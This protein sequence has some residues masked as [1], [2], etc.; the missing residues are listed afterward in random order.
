MRGIFPSPSF[1]TL[2][3]SLFSKYS[4]VISS[5]FLF[6]SSLLFFFSLFFSFLFL[7]FLTFLI[8]FFKEKAIPLNQTIK[9]YLFQVYQ[10][11]ISIWVFGWGLYPSTQKSLVMKSSMSVTCRRISRVGKGRGLRSSCFSSAVIWLLYTWASPSVW[12]KSPG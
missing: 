8:S 12:M 2:F 4:T 9:M 3:L 5:P 6:T 10:T 1:D 7:F 11:A